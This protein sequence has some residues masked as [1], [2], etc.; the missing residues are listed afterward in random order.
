MPL[1]FAKIKQLREAAGLTLKQAGELAGYDAAQ[2]RQRWH[3]FEA[4][5]NPDPKLSTLERICTV[6]GC[7]AADILT[8]DSPLLKRRR[9]R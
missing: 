3:F 4:G 9:K 5:T 2:A 1:D 7:T 6:L 8:P